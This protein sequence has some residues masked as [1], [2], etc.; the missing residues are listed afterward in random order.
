MSAEATEVGRSTPKLTDSHCHLDFE[1]FDADRDTL[2]RES[3]Q[4]LS[5]IIIPGVASSNWRRVQALCAS[6]GAICMPLMV[7]IPCGLP[8][9]D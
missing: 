8:G 1:C 5:A 3:K 2:I 7:F 4:L 9:R 6:E